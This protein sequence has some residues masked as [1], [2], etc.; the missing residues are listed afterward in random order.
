MIMSALAQCWYLQNETKKWEK[1][2]TI[3]CKE[4]NKI[5][6]SRAAGHEDV[7]LEEVFE[8][9]EQTWQ[10]KSTFFIAF[11]TWAKQVQNS[12]T[13]PSKTENVGFMK[14]RKDN[15]QNAPNRQDNGLLFLLDEKDFFHV[16][17]DGRISKFVSSTV[18]LR[19]SKL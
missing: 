15:E 7:N 5:R 6:M 16:C 13:F 8:E 2:K 1:Q 4:Q 14:E 3:L 12:K 17:T 18:P 11:W 9:S 10:I 19:I